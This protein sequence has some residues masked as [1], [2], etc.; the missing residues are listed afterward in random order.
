MRV[1]CVMGPTAVGKSDLAVVLARA[2]DGEVVNADS[3]QVFRHLPIG[4]AA[5]APDQRA[6]APHHLFAYLDPDREPDAGDWARR[7]AD[8]MAGIEARGRLPVL[9]GGT[10]FWMR[11]LFEG[12]SGIPPV[13][14]EARAAV[15]DAI[16]RDGVEAAWRRLAGLDPA[17]AA[18]LAPGDT[19]RIARALEVHEAT[20]VPLSRFQSLPPEP[21]VRADVL[22]LVPM[23]PREALYARIDA[24]AAAMF[25]AGLVD[26]VR[27]V[28]SLGF[29]ADVRPLR[30]SG[31]LPVVDFL[32]G[33]CDEAGM[34]ERVAR[35]HRNYAKRQVTWLRREEGLRLDPTAGWDEALAACR[36]FLLPRSGGNSLS[37]GAGSG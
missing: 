13:P 15:L 18:R 28:L 27:T 2:F 3:M 19:Q 6:A 16:A 26:E 29:A 21:V 22:R 17:T 4:T 35:G 8:V 1:V 25:E 11:A 12:L 24:R 33:R 32:Q 14:A 20:G 5:P 23:L 10:F 34:R 31:Y 37:G 9:V 36:R 7:A 30:T